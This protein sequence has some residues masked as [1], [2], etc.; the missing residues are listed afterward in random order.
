M[1]STIIAASE[2]AAIT[3]A[4]GLAVPLLKILTAIEAAVPI[5]ICSVPNSEEAVPA[6]FWKCA[7]ASAAAFG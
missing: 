1:I 2:D 3:A 7:R 5:P 4:I 6:F